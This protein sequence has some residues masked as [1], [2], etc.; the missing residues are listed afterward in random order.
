MVKVSKIMVTDILTLTKEAKVSNAIKLMANKTQGCVLIIEDK[1]PIG[2]I[3]ESDI[4]KNIAYKK[5]NTN[6][7]V[8]KIMSYPITSIRSNTK[9][10]KVSKIIDTK[11][12]KRY[13][14]VEDD[15]LIGLLTE[16]SVVHALNDNVR[17]HRN[18]QN[19][20]LILFVIFELFVFILY[21]HLV[22][23]LAFL[24]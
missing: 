7:K 24:R 3:T 16:N 13:P 23:F 18:I 21:K 22:N 11:H 12:F 1:K 5:I 19:S 10:E 17:F 15:G 4:I 6:E 8:T 14:V 20:V 2:I 9:L